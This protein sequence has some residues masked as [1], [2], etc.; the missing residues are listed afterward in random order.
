[1]KDIGPAK[2]IGGQFPATTLPKK[3]KRP[4]FSDFEN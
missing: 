2:K 1:M 3:S 4:L